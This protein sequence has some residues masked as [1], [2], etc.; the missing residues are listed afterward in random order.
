M[1]EVTVGVAGLGSV[2]LKVARALDKGLPGLRLACVCASTPDRAAQRVAG[3]RSAPVAVSLEDLPQRAS[4]VIE[5]LPPELFPAIAGPVLAAGGT[6]VVAS[7]GGLLRHREL[8]QDPG[9]Q[10]GRIVVPS[11]A[12]AGLDALA[13]AREAGLHSVKLVTRKPPAAFDDGVADHA[14]ARCIFSGTATEAV[15][16]FPKNINVAA[17]V[18]LAGLGPEATQ[19]EI[20]ADPAVSQNTHELFIRSE[21]GEIYVRS[22]NLPDPE[23]PK[24]SAVT[25]HSIVAALRRMTGPLCI[26]T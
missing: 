23:N 21:A 11:G 18:S 1:A 7:V 2:G 26:G 14:Q 5:C 22:A 16:R 25:G 17:T 13:A 20:W 9:L 8:L 3:F 15:A 10:R 12:V 6:L 24:S 19:V 4:V